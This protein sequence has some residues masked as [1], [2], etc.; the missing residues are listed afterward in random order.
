MVHDNFE[1]LTE[2]G[3]PRHKNFGDHLRNVFTTHPFLH[4]F[5]FISIITVD[6]AET[7]SDWLFLKDILYLQEGLVYG[8]VKAQLVMALVL[9]SGIGCITIVFEV[10]N[11]TRKFLTGRPWIDMDIV[12]A[13]VIWLEEVP[14]LTVNFL[15]TM[16]HNEPVSYFQLAKS[17]VVALSVIV[18]LICQLIRAYLD[19]QTT[20]KVPSKFRASVFKFFANIGMCLI[21]CGSIAVF[22][23]THVIA[24]DE[25]KFEFRMPQEIWAGH[26]AYDKY[27]TDV[28][29]YFNHEA[30][31]NKD[32]RNYWINLA[33]ID[34]F[35]DIDSI[36]IK[37]TLSKENTNINRVIV[38][39]YNTT[40]EQ[41][42]E[43][44]EYRVTSQDP[45]FEHV[46]C[47]FDFISENSKKDTILFWF[48]FRRPQ[49]HLILGDIAYNAKFL[50]NNV[51]YD[52][53]ANQTTII[54]SFGN[55]PQ[56]NSPI[57]R[58]LYLKRNSNVRSRQR[59]VPW[60]RSFNQS[61]GKSLYDIDSTL[62]GADDIWN[63]GMY[64][65]KCS[66]RDGPTFD[67]KLAL[68]C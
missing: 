7:V 56:K 55:E 10:I 30:I 67:K 2:E 49:K 18:R 34:D 5:L 43:C 8:P 53:N 26:Y 24:T 51:C 58:L 14:T 61:T 17:I 6:L 57:G 64:G 21:L 19:K 41:F 36:H 12:S 16:C 9:T 35:F 50:T 66:G 13:V 31:T 38:N 40:G 23:F 27:F 48:Y 46:N 28:G 63:T 15:I 62:L 47:T 20:N 52:V 11:T 22:I 1:L 59:L 25:R 68:T 33:D 54:Q 3:R 32:K 65:C 42:R 37:V 39:S 44:Y 29:I 45:I 60:T 4:C